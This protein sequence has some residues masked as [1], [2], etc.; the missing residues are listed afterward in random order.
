MKYLYLA[1]FLLFFPQC[2][3]AQEIGG[4]QAYTSYRTINDLIVDKEG[5]IWGVTEGGLFKYDYDEV[6]TFF[7][8]ID[9]MSRLDGKSLAYDGDNNLL[10][11]GYIDGII[12]VYNI[13]TSQFS[14]L[15]DIERVTSYSSKGINDILVSDGSLFV[16]TEFGIV[17]FDIEGL[18]V[19]DS[20]LQL[21]D[22]MR[23]MSV[24]DI[25]IGDNKIYC[26][27]QEGVAVGN[28]SKE[29][30]VSSNWEN[31]NEN[32]GFVSK[33]VQAIAIWNGDLYASTAD[34]NYIF[35]G[36]SWQ[37]NA[38]FGTNI[39][40]DYMPV[41]DNELAALSNKNLH[42]KTSG[43]GIT[44]FYLDGE[45]GVSLGEI[46][47]SEKE[48]IYLGSLNEGIGIFAMEV[49]E[50]NFIVPNGP[51]QNYFDGMFFDNGTFVAASS[52]QSVRNANIDNGKGYYLFDGSNWKNFNRQTN[53]HIDSAGFSLAFTTAK[54]RDYYYFGSWGQG[55]ARHNKNTD[56]IK[57]FDEK[58]STLRGWSS[59]D[60]FYP[61]ISGLQA[62]SEERIWLVS[63]YGDTPLY[64]QTPG[65]NDWI[66]FSKNSAV[67]SSDE[68]YTLFIDSY[69]QKWIGLQNTSTAG[70]G[71][72]VLNTGDPD[73]PTDDK[74]EKLTTTDTDGNLPDNQVKAI[75]EDKNGE[76][77]IGT[78]RGIAKFIFPEYIIGS[79]SE[80]RKAQ[81]LIN[82]DTSATSRYL[83]R[84]VNVTTIAVNGANEKWIG[85][86]NQGIWVLNAEGSRIEKRITA[87]N[88][89]L[90]SNNIVFIAINH[91]TGEVYI[92][93]DLGL[94]IYSDVPKAP[95]S[96]MKKLKIYPNP[97]VYSKHD[98]IIIEGLSE[99]T[100]IKILGVDG[101]VVNELSGT[102]GRISW[103]G[104][105]FSGSKLGSGV[106]FIVALEED[107]SEKGVGK[108]VIIK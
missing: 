50:L 9:G 49:S 72:L 27:T 25:T 20:Y 22:F 17:V 21:G 47:A 52:K 105:D 62:D 5:S 12:D 68:Y 95:V 19:S 32:N 3:N 99:K 16:A 67:S 8:T 87:E 73:D 59:D 7:T 96:K 80:E 51:Y 31:Y 107:G 78:A 94:M 60:P 24:L 103:N 28:L 100:N 93:T 54:A 91:E 2:T 70:V 108:V 53:H 77:W 58:N 61:V 39:I 65:D 38:E 98:M 29:L 101:S 14:A 26:G 57:I 42:I 64:Y 34:G 82:E 84:D 106:Y 83:L 102:G 35:N 45:T 63:R 69:D 55:V 75:V 43:S 10:F 81:W 44:S 18:Y 46:H 1:L 13:E 86:V 23:G 89:P 74:G 33:S 41:T 71:L 97:F 88:S 15:D 90:F 66:P 48:R 85:S 6:Y 4:W 92:A 104:Y 40:L 37:G 76:V 30:T 79:G 56:E 11:I 36:E